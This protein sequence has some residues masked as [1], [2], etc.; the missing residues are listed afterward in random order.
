[1]KKLLVLAMSITFAIGLTACSSSNN[2]GTEKKTKE[3]ST[4]S[5]TDVKKPLVKFYMDFTNKINAKDADLNAY[6]AAPDASLKEKASAS[7]AAVASEIKAIQIPKELD[8]QKADL[9]AGLKDI[10]DSYQAKADELKKA[11][12]SL[13]AANATFTKGVDELGKVFESVKLFKPDFGKGV[14]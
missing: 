1:M 4:A 10:A 3:T 5:Q 6:E 9:N 11:T 8:K 12:P 7:A 14:N 13:D 2:G